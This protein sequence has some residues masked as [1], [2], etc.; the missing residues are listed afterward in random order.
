MKKRGMDLAPLKAGKALG[1]LAPL[2]TTKKS[3]PSK[4]KK[5]K[6]K[7][8][9]HKAVAADIS[10]TDNIIANTVKALSSEEEPPA[11][12]LEP[13]PPI[14]VGSDSSDYDYNFS[15]DEAPPAT[16]TPVAIS[17]PKTT[18]A[19][20]TSTTT[21]TIPRPHKADTTTTT[22]AGTTVHVSRRG[23]V[24][25]VQNTSPTDEFQETKRQET[26]TN[27]DTNINTSNT[28]IT[29]NSSNSSTR[30]RSF[31][32]TTHKKTKSAR[33]TSSTRSKPIHEISRLSSDIRT[34][35]SALD[36]AE[37]GHV[38][39]ADAC[40][41]D[42][43][44]RAVAE[45]LSSSSVTSLDLRGNQIRADGA[46]A[47]AAALSTNR[48]LRTLSLEWNSLGL[49]PEGFR[50]MAS[51][52]AQPTSSLT[53]IDMRN[54]RLTADAGTALASALRTNRSLNTIDL[55]WNALGELGTRSLSR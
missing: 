2:S 23:S 37:N 21:T 6:S 46:V 35:L 1:G 24:N 16:T 13:I 42:Y 54:N 7:K 52:L 34:R 17:S 5:K 50:A 38:T 28:S 33:S 14:D 22:T 29:S 20:T 49:F 47:L 53:S 11:V 48:S 12:V 4:K 19:T 45:R 9:Q 44:C 26:K 15:D 31:K 18:I 25:I 41:G 36:S 51:M 27:T 55:R 43:G 3:S 8:K 39:L 30:S 40:L 10:Y 32:A